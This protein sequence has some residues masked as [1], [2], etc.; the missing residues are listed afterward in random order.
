M[1]KKEPNININIAPDIKEIKQEKE[2]IKEENNEI[3]NKDDNKDKNK[4]SIS[5]PKEKINKQFLEMKLIFKMTENGTDG[6]SFHRFCDKKG[7]TLIL[8]KTTKNKIFGGFTPLNWEN[9]GK[10]KIDES[11]Q[12]FIF[13]LNLNKKFDMINANRKAIQGFS[14]DY[15]PNFGDY[16]LGLKNSLKEGMTYANSSC[17]YLSNNK[18]ELT[19]G[20]GDNDTFQT[21]EFEVYQVIY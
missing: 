15:G 18:L 20:N 14:V 21:E 8:I 9:N 6:K 13:S 1:E 3:N 17:N 11:N 2:K 5:N 7:P 19:G 4:I 16:D 12:T 10:S